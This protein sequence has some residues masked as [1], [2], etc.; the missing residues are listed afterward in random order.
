VFLKTKIKEIF[1]N[2]QTRYFNTTTMSNR[3]S[4]LVQFHSGGDDYCPSRECEGLSDCIGN[5]PADGVLFAW[6]DD[7]TR[8]AAEGE[9]RI[10][11]LEIDS[12]TNAPVRDSSGNMVVAAEIHL[13]ND[14]DIVISG[15]KD[16]NIVVLGDAN[17]SVSGALD[18]EA[19]N[20][21]SSG[22]WVHD[23]N[24]TASHIE[25]EDGASGTYTQSVTTNKGIATEGT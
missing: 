1:H 24:F 4:K 25:A 21:T 17:L 13:K 3:A 23:G 22:E 7:A 12:D 19:A 6:R 10:Y 16:L 15:G 20:I 18:I 5:N 14:G 11:S 2:L 9:K 8:K